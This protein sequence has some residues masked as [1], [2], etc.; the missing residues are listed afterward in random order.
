MSA[1]APGWAAR[2]ADWLEARA[3]LSVLQELARKKQV[4][5]R[6]REGGVAR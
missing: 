2:I 5:D 6:L 3:G 1:D 4:H